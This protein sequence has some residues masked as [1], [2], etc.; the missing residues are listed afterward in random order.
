M[1]HPSKADPA[2]APPALSGRAGG[3]ANGAVNRPVK[4]ALNTVLDGVTKGA[5]S[6]PSRGP[7]RHTLDNILRAAGEILDEAG[8]EGFNTTA[9]AGSPGVFDYT[10]GTSSFHSTLTHTVTI[11]SSWT[12]LY[13]R[14][15]TF[16]IPKVVGHFT[17]I[18]DFYISSVTA[19]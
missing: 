1:P 3:L 18:N 6:T 2:L 5:V 15:H 10:L 8:Y 16:A 14:V 11:D 17:F 19:P 12:G 9:V 4:V 7:G 13:N